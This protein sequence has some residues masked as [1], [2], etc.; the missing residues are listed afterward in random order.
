MSAQQRS[1]TAKRVCERSAKRLE[2]GRRILAS[3]VS[4]AL[5]TKYRRLL[6]S[7]Y[8]PEIVWFCAQG[9]PPLSITEWLRQYAPASFGEE[10]V[11]K[12][13]LQS[14]ITR[15]RKDVL[16]LY[17][18]QIP[19][20]SVR[21]ASLASLAGRSF[22][23]LRQIELCILAQELRVSEGMEAESHLGFPDREV[24]IELQRLSKMLIDYVTLRKVIGIA[25]ME[26]ELRRTSPERER[27]K[28]WVSLLPEEMQ[29]Q[30]T[31]CFNYAAAKEA[32]LEHGEAD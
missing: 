18:K 14:Q 10:Q 21:D 9:Y 31:N 26:S 12:G 20:V 7:S 16:A 15:L 32:A 30:L 11:K 1:A 17:R 8:A 22:N 24:G 23:P 29:K 19:F 4:L 2:E 6:G 28:N 3:E 27:V 13:A 25:P 5:K